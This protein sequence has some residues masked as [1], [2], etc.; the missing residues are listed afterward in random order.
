VLNKPGALTEEERAWIE[1]HPAAEA[2][3]DQPRATLAATP[4]Q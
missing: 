1:Q 4:S 3:H 2:C